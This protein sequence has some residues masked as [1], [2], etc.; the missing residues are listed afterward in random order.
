VPSFHV[1]YVN[2]RQI[3]S[4]D[5]ENALEDYLKRSSDI[6]F[7]LTP[8]EVRK[9]AFQY[10]T[11]LK[12]TNIPPT[13]PK[14][15]CAGVDW[16]KKFMKRHKGLSVR[17][18]EAT[19][20]ARAS[21]FNKVNVEAFFHN[22][23]TVLDRHSYGPDD[24]WNVDE[25]GI[26][27]VQR[28][29]R[30]VARRGVKQVGAV[31]SSERGTL[32]TMAL[33]ISAIGNQVPPFFVFPRA[34]YRDHFLANGPPGSWGTANPSGWMKEDNFF[35]FIKF[36]V[37][38]TR[39]SKERPL[40]LLL[41]NH[42][43]HLSIATLDYCKE[44]G[45]TV[46]SFPPHCSHKLQPLDRSVY[47]P[48]KHYVNTA[49]DDWMRTHPGKTMSIYDIPG[50]VK[51]ALPLA[52]TPRNNTAGFQC[53]GIYPL[54]RHIFGELD[55]APGY[56]TDRPNPETAGTPETAEIA[57]TTETAEIPE[58]DVTPRSAETVTVREDVS[59]N[60]GTPSASNPAAQKVVTPDSLRPLP[61]AKARI[62]TKNPRNNA[63]KRFTA[64]LTDTPVKKALEEKKAAT[65]AKRPAPKDKTAQKNKKQTRRRINLENIVPN[66]GDN[67]LCSICGDPWQGSK[68]N[69][70]WKRC[71]ECK[72]WSHQSCTPGSRPDFVCLECIVNGYD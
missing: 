30:V 27:T 7:G 39:C 26:T 44:N 59:H 14:N 58:T 9:F 61:K 2:S 8:K 56:A 23:T 3:F 22:L 17:K 10:A 38:S 15:E 47:G 12:L 16:F 41:D 29:N 19:S 34:R 35:E 53:S 62:E 48:F 42:D 67:C 72:Q 40:L 52:A 31:T 32:V 66:D 20:L 60:Q 55:Y 65:A 57:E 63:R 51:I 28:P 49:C 6:Y 11:A 69:E 36:F 45:V 25:T 24:I 13:W 46:L 4:K 21:S 5:Q 54:N 37:H 71:L 18:P 33:A 64:I 50:I 43:S 68:M 70:V 1:G